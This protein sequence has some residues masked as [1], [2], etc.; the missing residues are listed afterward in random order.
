MSRRTSAAGWILSL[1]AIPLLLCARPVEAQ[2]IAGEYQVEVQG[3]TSYLD[4][5]PAQQRLQDNTVLTVEQD[6]D[7]IKVEFGG[8]A[9]AMSTTIFRG[10]V[11]NG[12]FVA[13]WTS[14]SNPGE[15]R[16]ITGEVVGDRLRGRLL[17]PRAAADAAVPGWTEIEF[18]AVRRGGPERQPASPLPGRMTPAD[19][20]RR[21][22]VGRVPAQ[23]S[24]ADADE[25]RFAVDV[26]AMTEPEAPLAGHRIEFI[27]RVTPKRSGE[28]VERTELWINGLVQGSSDGGLLEVEAG[29]FN[30]GRLEYQIRAISSQGSPSEL[31]T[32]RVDVTSAGNTT[33][34]G[35]LAGGHSSITDVQLVRLD[36]LTVARSR[37]DG[38]GRYRLTGIPAGDYV[39]FVNDAKNEAMVSPTSN[40]EIRVDGRSSYTR[41]FEVRRP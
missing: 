36:G 11:G 15:A 38:N 4:R 28:S 8:F 27:A 3:T 39:I 41:D 7:T 18:S 40:L 1:L 6:G 34:S 33:I 13:L 31:I 22:P 12:R 23:P 5:Q 20:L 14:P 35:R 32:R 30:A 26:M 19:R 29:P 24:G 25:A 16:L 2:E 9:G 37:V 21:P 10:R 17:Y